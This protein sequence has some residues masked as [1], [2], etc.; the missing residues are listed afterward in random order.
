MSDS[1]VQYHPET[2]PAFKGI[3]TIE[4]L[5]PRVKTSE[6]IKELADRP[7]YSEE[8]RNGS[9]EDRGMFVQNL[10]RLYQPCEKDIDIYQKVERCIRWGYADRNPFSPQFIQ[11]QQHEFAAQTRGEECVQYTQSYHT[12]SGFALLGISGLGKSTTLRHVLGRYP[13]VIHHKNYN[14]IPFNETQ[15]TWIHMDCPN[16]GSLK[17]LCEVFFEHIDALLGTNYF[18]QYS[19]KR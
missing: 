4:C 16:D 11:Q 1:V 2:F 9:P 5:P 14:G 7:D 19:G 15:I 12:T 13:Q 18:S 10:L 3:P 6:V 17:G 8:D